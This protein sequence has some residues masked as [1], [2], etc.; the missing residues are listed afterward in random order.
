VTGALAG[1]G[2]NPGLAP[3]L[4]LQPSSALDRPVGPDYVLG[5]GDGV[6]IALWGGVS[7]TVT[8]TVDSSGSIVLPEAGPLTVAGLKLSQAQGLIERTLAPQF[9]DVHAAITLSRLRTVRIYVV[10][11]VQRPGA[12]DVPAQSTPLN[13]LYAAGGPT[14]TGSLRVLRH[15]RGNDLVREVDLYDFLLRGAHAETDSL[16]EG[17]TILVPPVGPQVAVS[18]SVRRPAVYELKGEAKLAEILNDAGGTQVTAALGRIM[19]ERVAANDHRETVFIGVGAANTAD[20]QKVIADFAVKD[21]DRVFVSS[22]APWSERI[23]YV[24]GHVVRPGRL[25]YRDR[26][27]LTDVLHSYQDLLPE[28]ADRGQI[29]RLVAPDLHPEAIE[30]DVAEVVAGNRPI[31]LQP[32]DTI[33]IRGR[34]ESDAPKVTVQGEVLKPG[35]Y[36]MANGMTAGELVKMAGG[37]TR[38]ALLTDADLA[39]YEIRGGEAVT[40]KRTTV[41]IGEDVQHSGA[42]TDTLLKAGD[43]LTVHQISGWADIGSSVKVRGEVNHPGSYGIE[44]GETLSSV[45]LRAGG[46]R[47]T[48]YPMGAILLRDEVRDLEE[49]S[50]EDLIRQIESTPVAA[51][52]GTDISGQSQAATLQLL[53]QQQQEMLRQLRSQPANGRLVVKIDGDIKLWAHTSADIEMR[54]GDTLIIPKRPGFVLVSGQVY[55]ATA[56]TFVPYKTAGW[57][58]KQAGG[59]TELA[60]SREIRIVRAN[61]SIIG[62]HS[63]SWYGNDVLSTRL[64]AGDSIVVPEKIVRLHIKSGLLQPVGNYLL[65]PVSKYLLQLHSHLWLAIHD[66]QQP[67]CRDRQI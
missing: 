16:E 61:G 21:G 62:R 63:G 31:E 39:S 51:Q 57:Y 42:A 4:M 10:G 18:G 29:I 37:F 14:A 45:L 47:E 58:L 50:K 40:S 34:Y 1:L 49:K 23:V 53:Q 11:D 15:M 48:A 54:T 35:T 52:L 5:P 19:I 28:P 12:Y 22:I 41:P 46:Y 56:Q 66:P 55:N 20:L 36:S 38:G 25:P 33:R 3:D 13:A 8:R 9:R 64:N 24:E 30:F 59:A 44:Q 6:T 27:M 2:A 43:V 67:L 60:N 7:Q 26:M 17:D 32:F 65:Q